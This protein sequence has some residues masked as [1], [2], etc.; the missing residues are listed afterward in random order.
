MDDANHSI[1]QVHRHGLIVT[2]VALDIEYRDRTYIMTYFSP[3][4]FLLLA[5]YDDC[6][7][8]DNGA[9]GIEATGHQLPCHLHPISDEHPRIGNAHPALFSF[10]I[11][12]C[13]HV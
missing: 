7:H 4:I 3:P 1:D 13:I 5:L 11:E 9:S 10:V 12:C 6:I 2:V 8:R